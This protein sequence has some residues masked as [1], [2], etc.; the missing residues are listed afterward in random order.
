MKNLK[1]ILFRILSALLIYILVIYRNNFE[2]K[3]G[4]NCFGDKLFSLSEDIY[5]IMKNYTSLRKILQIIHFSYLDYLIVHVSYIWVLYGKRWRLFMSLSL[6]FIFKEICANIFEIKTSEDII[7]SYPGIHSF[8]L[9]Y[10]NNNYFFFSGS[11][12][13]YLIC[14]LE[15]K[16]AGYNILWKI[17]S[18]FMITHLILLI[19]F[20]AQ[21]TLCIFCGFVSSHY[22]QIMSDKYCNI[23]NEFYD[24]NPKETE[25]TNQERRE[26]EIREI[27]EKSIK[28]YKNENSLK[29]KTYQ[30]LENEIEL[31]VKVEDKDK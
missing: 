2:L 7:W 16:S 9:S 11:V 26:K 21:F 15:L 29:N 22:L 20:R 24:F 17:S 31:E 8:T 1:I 18:I 14:I 23:L 27:I 13:I 3:K 6:F 30:Q 19:S 5:L 28:K 10:H 4:S 12:G 25:K